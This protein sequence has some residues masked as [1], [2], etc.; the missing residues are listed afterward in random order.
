MSARASA[1]LDLVAVTRFLDTVVPGGLQGQLAAELI[2]G[3]RSNPTYA[4]T[5]GTAQWVLR[6]PPYGLVLPS[7]HDMAREV[8]VQSALAASPVPVPRIVAS[9]PDPDVIGAPFYVMDR[10]AGRMMSALDDTARLTPA[11]RG[12]FADALV[13]ELAT[14]HALDPDAVGLAGWGRP[15]GFLDRQLTLWLRQWQAA[16]TVDRPALLDVA[17]RLRRAMPASRRAGIVHG[18]YK[19]DNVMVDAHDTGRVVA[20]LDWEMSTLGDPLCDLGMLLCF[21]DE[22]DDATPNP[23]AGQATALDGFP[24]RAELATRYATL[25]GTD[26]SPVDWYLAFADFKL[27]VI[28]DGIH[29]RYVAGATA[30]H[31]FDEI[32]RSIQPLLDRAEQRTRNLT[33]GAA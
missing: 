24:T 4:L 31:G 11:E 8:R 29:A 10:V 9:C 28:L 5:D 12:A 3:G 27:S 1:E 20:I 22:V 25:S 30:G 32:G 6:R 14:L 17:A 15:E 19:Y 21:W 33:I 23:H 26:V 7:A 2:S 16:H 18:D 13:R